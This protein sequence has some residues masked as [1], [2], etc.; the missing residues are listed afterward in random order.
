MFGTGI[1]PLKCF[2]F[3]HVGHT[4]QKI[5]ANVAFCGVK[6][7]SDFVPGDVLESRRGGVD[8]LR[9]L[10]QELAT[11][12]RNGSIQIQRNIPD[13]GLR[14]GHLLV[15]DGSLAA[16]FHRAE[17]PRYGIEALLE[18][19][20]DAMALDAVMSLHELTESSY[21]TAVSQHPE[22]S[23]I[24]DDHKQR[25]E[26]WWTTVR[27]PRRRLEREERLPEVKPTVA[28][29]EALRRRSEARLRNR[30]G[31]ILQQ[32]Q[33]WLEHAIEP[34]TMF[35]LA[36]VL[37]DLNQ[38]A[39]VI[40][41][42]APTRISSTHNIDLEH[43]FWLSETEHERTL[44]PSLQ[45]I[46]KTVDTFFSNNE[47]CLLFLEGIEYLLGIHGELRVIEMI[48]SVVDQT[49]SSGNLLI[50]SSN[51]QAFT[52]VQRSRL[53][54][55]F[56]PLSTQQ[57]N[58]WLLDKELLR[59]HPFFDEINPDDEA[60]IASHLEA[61]VEDP[62][63]SNATKPLPQVEQVPLPLEYQT[64]KVDEELQSKMRTW[65]ADS[66]NDVSEETKEVVPILEEEKP[67]QTAAKPRVAQRIKRKRKPSSQ[68][69]K[70]NTT[71][72]AAKRNIV[73]PNLPRAPKIS[74]KPFVPVGSETAHEFPKSRPS[75]SQHSLNQA[76]N[77]ATQKKIAAFPPIKSTVQVPVLHPQSEQSEMNVEPSPHA[78][79]QA[80]SRQKKRNSEDSA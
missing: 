75:L 61:N 18:I 15:F 10:A 31:S 72:A 64:R 43:Y 38:T 22:S 36:S 8:V 21:I 7:V 78:R 37:L 49:R 67:L 11:L 45:S 35:K 39:L 42:Q 77:N 26:A 62:V 6:I 56:T 80:S 55:E 5:K 48:R 63:V 2:S 76:A 34:D 79:E 29:P 52:P 44:E 40:S 58:T 4:V 32:G 12:E 30:G 33:A 24:A 16:A 60:A 23:L 59:E 47:R 9:H 19:E 71:D 13:V 14:E 54:R 46:G 57:I 53:E 51:L 41:R 68:P 74:Q 65:A 28:V 69:K 1:R 20:S 17:I 50:V 70:Q 73:L 25:D 66:D 27:A 3:V